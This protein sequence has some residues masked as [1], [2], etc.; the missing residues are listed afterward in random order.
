M[1]TTWILMLATLVAFAGPATADET[2]SASPVNLLP[3]GSFEVG[4]AGWM[5][6]ETQI[7]G[8]RWGVSEADAAHGRRALF[9]DQREAAG[10][11]RRSRLQGPWFEHGETALLVSAM[12][13]ADEPCAIAIGLT[14]G[15][16]TGWDG[17]DPLSARETFDIGPEWRRV[18]LRVPRSLNRPREQYGERNPLARTV[19]TKSMA[20]LELNEPRTIWIDAVQA[21]AT[22]DQEAYPPPFAPAAPVELG[23]SVEHGGIFHDRPRFEAVVANHGNTP[24]DGTL[25]IRIR[26][27]A[28]RMVQLGT[29]PVAVAPGDSVTVKI[30]LQDDALGFFKAA[31]SLVDARHREVATEHLTMVRTEEGPGS[32]CIALTANASFSDNR[33]NTIRSAERLGFTQVRTYHMCNW[34]QCVPR[35]GAW[36][37]PAPLFER[38]F[39]ES[40]I[41]T[42]VNFQNPPEWVIGPDGTTFFYPPQSLDAYRDYVRRAVSE[43]EPWVSSAAFVNEP[44]AHYHGSDRTYLAYQDAMFKTVRETAPGV[45]LCGLQPGTGAH[46]AF[47]RKMLKLGGRKL[48]GD[49]DVLAVQTHPFAY[50]P[51]EKNGWDRLQA[52]LR[53]VAAEY[54]IERIWTTEMGFETLAPEEDH[55][56]IRTTRMTLLTDLVHTERT[57]ADRLTR[58]ALYGLAST[59]ERFYAFHFGPCSPYNGILYQWSYSRNNHLV[60]PRPALAALAVANRMIAGTDRRAVR[61]WTTPGLW[62]AT[63]TGDGRRVD[64]LWSVTGPQHVR[65]TAPEGVRVH[66]I[67]GN[68]IFLADDG[69]ALLE[70]GESPVYLVSDDPGRDPVV[71]S[72]SVTWEPDSV[73]SGGPFRG[74]IGLAD[75]GL[76]LSALRLRHGETG[77]ELWSADAPENGG[78]PFAFDLDDV[79]GGPLPLA[80]EGVMED[81]RVFVRRLEPMVMGDQAGRKAFESGEPLVVEDFDAVEVDG[82]EARTDRDIHLKAEVLFP[83]FDIRGD[84][85][86]RALAAHDGLVRVTIEQPV[87]K[88]ARGKPDWQALEVRM[89]APLNW[90]AYR[91]LRIRYRRDR[92][93][94][95]GMLMP[96]PRSAQGISL[97]LGTAD[98]SSFFASGGSSGPSVARDGDWYIA[99]LPFDRVAGLNEK[100]A[101]VNYLQIWPNG[102]ADDEDPF[103]FSI[104]RIDVVPRLDD[105]QDAGDAAVQEEIN[106][107]E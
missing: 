100:R 3:N 58:A 81:G 56:P 33:V 44:N 8:T 63:F 95:D 43:I 26:D 102:P 65:L 17:P 88:Q 94:D 47:V 10:F 46:A 25:H 83:W 50:M 71:E 15:E 61:E 9:I 67:M 28:D 14:H 82:T 49:M 27:Y 80:I 36:V 5:L 64:A 75:E 85:V 45:T 2:P 32:D 72:L 69:A 20:Y 59:F 92:P 104:D 84:H 70:L 1:K 22:D 66:D 89:D 99:T 74:A 54:G 24:W 19:H 41:R 93:G 23:W 57:Q 34:Q 76:S 86:A 91:A 62:G 6:V 107:A 40:G 13:R 16:I 35:E 77:R 98:G 78:M 12:V 105:A 53:E 101:G 51:I 96:D 60:T 11:A 29:E 87:G 79:P 37:S 42:M 106:Y 7:A 18:V 30:S 68:R 38:Y 73:W 39:G 21:N 97:R 55:M 31:L 48:A 52:D 4:S 90:L 103:G